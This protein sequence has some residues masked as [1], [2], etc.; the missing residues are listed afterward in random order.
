M[1]S[2]DHRHTDADPVRRPSVRRRRCASALPV[3]RHVPPTSAPM[4]RPAGRSSAASAFAAAVRRPPGLLEQRLEQVVVL[5]VARRRR[6]PCARGG[7]PARAASRS[8]STPSVDDRLA[9][10]EDRVA[11]ADV[12]P[13]SASLCSSNTRSSGV[14]STIADLLEHDLPLERRDRSSRSAGRKTRSP[15]HVGRLRRGARRARAPDTT[16]CSRDVYASSDP[17]SALE[18]QRDLL[19]AAPSGALEHHVLEEVRHAHLLARLVQRSRAHP[20]PKRNRPHSRH[21]LREYGQSIGQR[22][23]G[24]L[25]AGLRSRLRAVTRCARIAPARPPRPP[26]PRGAI[27]ARPS[28]AAVARSPPLRAAFA[29]RRRRRTAARRRR[30]SSAMPF[31]LRHQRLHR[32]TQASALVAIDAA[33]PSRGRP[34]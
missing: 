33:S 27:A 25:R 7:T 9:R 16:V 28:A 1:L 6:P 5:D 2:S 3:A 13:H 34:S 26:P 12:S 32:Q 8:S 29:A 30:C 14:S 22:R 18:R 20:G 10:A 11:V 15:M 19:R 21:V 23:C 17:P 31:R 4:R 24:E